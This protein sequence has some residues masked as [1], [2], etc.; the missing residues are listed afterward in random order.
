LPGASVKR[1]DGAHAE[2]EQICRGRGQ[3]GIP[4]RELARWATRLLGG[5]IPGKAPQQAIPLLQNASIPRKC[6]QI[7]AT[8]LTD[9]H[10]EVSSPRA[11]R[12]RDEIHIL[13]GEVDGRELA[14]GVDRAYRSIV[15]SH[16]FLER[17]LTWFAESHTDLEVM[18][19]IAPLE[20][21]A[22]AG[23][24]RDLQVNSTVPMRD[25]PFRRRARG[26]SRG[27]HCDRLEDR[28]F[29]AGIGA[30]GAKACRVDRQ[31]DPAERAEFVQLEH[32][33]THQDECREGVSGRR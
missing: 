21:T 19:A 12:S 10:V 31:L 3:F 18:D 25:F 20:L 23:I 28:G 33:Q 22:K 14:N 15:E 5:P 24:W 13:G 7:G 29:S 9:G 26:A 32:T 11:R 1:L 30:N 17:A 6:P 27:E 2:S 16:H 8:R 4:E